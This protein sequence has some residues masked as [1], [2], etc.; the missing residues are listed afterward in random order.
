MASPI[1]VQETVKAPLDVVFAA[2]TDWDRLGQ[3]MFQSLYFEFISEERT[4]P[5]T[6]WRMIIGEAENPTPAT[7]EILTIE[8]Q[9]SFVMTS[10]DASALETMTY[11]FRAVGQTTEV[12]FEVSPQSKGFLM[13]MLVPL[14]RGAV[15]KAMAED[16]SRMARDIEEK[17][18]RALGL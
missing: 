10:D 11:R 7:H 12:D 2:F 15:R 18:L 17:H 5:G 6:V 13:G 4:G 3:V 14:L 1:R 9:K 16:L 8:P